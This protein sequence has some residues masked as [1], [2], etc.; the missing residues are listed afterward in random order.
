MA[1]FTYLPRA[2][3]FAAE[4]A[5]DCVGDKIRAFLTEGE[6]RRRAGD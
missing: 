3:H 5:P 4:D 6:S 2:G 1:H